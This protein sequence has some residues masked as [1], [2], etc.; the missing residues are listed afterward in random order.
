MAI[1]NRKKNKVERLSIRESGILDSAF[2]S[3][4]ATDEDFALDIPEMPSTD[5]FSP[6][7]P[8]TEQLLQSQSNTPERA[9]SSFN[10]TKLVPVTIA[11]DGNTATQVVMLLEMIRYCMENSANVIDTSNGEAKEYD[12]RLKIR[13]R[14]KSNFLVSIGDESMPPIPV[15]ENEWFIGS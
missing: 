6:I 7:A 5:G 14:G 1:L 2:G 8:Q 9:G 10:E 11:T 4:D 15:S 12:I 3:G 13:N